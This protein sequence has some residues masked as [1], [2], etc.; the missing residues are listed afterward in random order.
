MENDPDEISE[1]G[2]EGARIGNAAPAL[3]TSFRSS[4][5]AFDPKKAATMARND[6]DDGD[7]LE[8]KVM[9]MESKIRVRRQN[10]QEVDDEGYTNYTDL[11]LTLMKRKKAQNDESFS[12]DLLRKMNALTQ[13][14]ESKIKQ[15]Y[16][17][18]EVNITPI[19]QK[20]SSVP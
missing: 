8:R 12:E 17:H 19:I 4:T 14:E 15:E 13:K 1:D 3:Y 9:E 5:L 7:S 16:D 18:G 2:Q 20:R 11:N 10:R 6:S